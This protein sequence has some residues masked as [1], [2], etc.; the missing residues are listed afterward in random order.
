PTLLVGQGVAGGGIPGATVEYAGVLGL[1]LGAVN[2]RHF[3]FYPFL[4]FAST[5]TDLTKLAGTYN[6][7][8]YHL[9]PTP[10]YENVATN[11]VETFDASGNCTSSSSSGCLT[12]GATLTPNSNGYFDSASA[13]Q[14]VNG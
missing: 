8:L 4:G 10:N 12:T 7:L 1:G 13:P 14:I 5:T 6:G 2:K 11:S 3:D 9:S